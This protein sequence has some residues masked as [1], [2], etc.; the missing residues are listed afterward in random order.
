MATPYYPPHDGGVE[1]YVSSL[2]R[3]IRLQTD[4]SVAVV[5]S[6]P[7]QSGGDVSYS[8]VDGVGIYRLPYRLRI[9]NTPIDRRWRQQ[10]KD[11]LRQEDPT[12]VN[13]HAPVPGLADLAASVVGSRPFVLTYHTGPMRKDGVVDD[14]LVRTYQRLVLPRTMR[15]ADA[16]IAGSEWVRSTLPAQFRGRAVTIHPGVDPDV[17]TPGDPDSVGAPVEALFVGTL[18]EG[19]RYKNLPDLLRA[20]RLLIDGGTEIS[21]RV[22]GDGGARAEYEELARSLGLTDQVTFTGSLAGAALTAEYRRTSFTVLPTLFDSFP[23]VLVEAMACGRPVI[24]TTTGGIAELVTPG[25][26][27]LLV[28]PGDVHSLTSAMKKLVDDPELRR[29]LGA[30]ARRNV[31]SR[32]SWHH[33]AQRTIAVLTAAVTERTDS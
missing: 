21:L 4:W 9:S 18:E 22:V 11:V 23:T 20:T 2:V 31:A 8:A 19:T 27:G 12:I 32:L 10:L 25:V 26:N 14:L 16:I 29:R 28:T 3:Q 24:S 13:A 5:T 15:R 7:E 1:R 17:F 33:Q 6:G 30:D